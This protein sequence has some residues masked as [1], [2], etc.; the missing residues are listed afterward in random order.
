MPVIKPTLNP[1]CNARWMQRIPMGPTG[2]AIAKLM[3]KPLMKTADDMTN[4]L[5][6]Q[7]YQYYY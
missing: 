5:A 6:E 1:F 3:I 7:F 2:A 4:S